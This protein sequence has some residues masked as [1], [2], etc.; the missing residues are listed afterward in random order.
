MSLMSDQS[1]NNPDNVDPPPAQ[2]QS[3]IDAL[4]APTA[5]DLARK[6]KVP[7]N[8]QHSGKRFVHPKGTS[9][10]NVSIRQRLT[11]FPGENFK[12]SQVRYF[13]L[14]VERKLG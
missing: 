8:L 10:P 13:V 4:K 9:N 12:E 11:E 5:S 1:A 14:V 3:I 6:R 7:C 2:R